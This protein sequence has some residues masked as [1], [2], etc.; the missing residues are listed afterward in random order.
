MHDM[1]A[2]LDAA[3]ESDAGRL[4]QFLK[5][6]ARNGVGGEIKLD[7]PDGPA[8]L[9]ANLPISYA[10]GGTGPQAAWVLARLGAKVLLA[11]ENRHEAMLSQIPPGVFVGSEGKLT[12]AEDIEGHGPHVPEVFIFEYTAGHPIGDL[13]PNRSSRVIIRFMAHGLQQ[14]GEFERVSRDV[15][16]T[17][18]AGLLSG[19]NDET[20]Q[21]LDS[22]IDAAFGMAEDW[23]HAGLDVI[24]LESADGYDSPAALEKVLNAAAGKVT[25]LGMSHSELLALYPDAHQPMQAMHALAKRLRLERVCVHADTWVASVTTGDPTVEKTALIA[26]S[27]IA[28][29]RAANGA[30]VSAV[31]VDANAVFQPLPFPESSALDNW[32]F[33]ACSTPYLERP[34]TTLGLGDS[35]T[36]GCLLVL[37]ADHSSKSG[38]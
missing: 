23:R 5:E 3:P 19:F 10:L 26:G 14:D 2:L 1:S 18:A 31:H 25:S 32:H 6:R 12:R 22:S 17:A 11:L 34:K 21:R 33:V 4:A 20:P 13:T 9:R 8:W 38:L 28:S 30:P 16:P 27:A 15:A 29:A 36:A 37:G 7:W 35:F 24:H